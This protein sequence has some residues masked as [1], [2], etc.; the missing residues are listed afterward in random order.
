MKRIKLTSKVSPRIRP[1]GAAA[2]LVDPRSVAAALDAKLVGT[3]PSGLS[4]PALHALRSEIS[5]RMTST[6]GRPGLAGTIRRQ[7][8][9]L[10][11]EDWTRLVRLARRLDEE[12]LHPTPGQVA[13]ALLRISLTNLEL[14]ESML[15]VQNSS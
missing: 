7:K 10:N 9:P 4:P 15:R 1:V 14:A 5:S 13:S 2:P 12:R 3:I 8:I 11:D 6:G